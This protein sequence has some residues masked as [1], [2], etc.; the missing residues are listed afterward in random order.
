VLFA[1][2]ANTLAEEVILKNG[3][4]LTG[5]IV[6]KSDDEVKLETEYAGTITIKAVHIKDI[7]VPGEKPVESP[8]RAANAA[9][10]KPADARPLPNTTSLFG[11]RMMG[12]TDGWEGNANIGFSFTGGN[13]R[14]STLTTGIRATKTGAIDKLT[15]YT[16]SQW[17]SNRKN[18]AMETTQNAVWGGARYDRDF[19]DK[20]F[21]FVSYDFERDRP[22]KLNFRSVLGGGAGHHTVKTESTELDLLLGGAWNRTWQTGENT[23]TP[24]ALAGIALKHKFHQRLKFQNSVSFFQNITDRNEYRVIFDATLSADITKRIG[25]FVTIGDRFNNDPVG[26]SQRNDVLLTTGIRWNFGTKK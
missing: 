7:L 20:M 25:W 5:K 16:R 19:D 23:D 8:K 2:A 18:G 15:V 22:K 9:T 14:T 26:A 12:L 24:E 10:V 11:G 17:Q 6:E 3:D 13:S 4:R 1:L 21:G